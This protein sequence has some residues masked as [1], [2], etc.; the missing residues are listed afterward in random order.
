MGGKEQRQRSHILELPDFKTRGGC[1]CRG[2]NLLPWEGYTLGTVGRFEAGRDGR[3][4][5]EVHLEL[6][7]VRHRPRICSGCGRPCAADHD[8]SERWVRDLPILGA[9][10]HLLV[11]R[12][13]VACP[14]C[15]PKV[16]RLAW[17]DPYAR[18]T[19]RLAENVA[20]LCKVLPV[21][22]VADYF[23]L[24]WKAVKRID[25]SYLSRTLGPVDLGGVTRLAIDEFAIQ[26]GHRY[27][28]VVIDPTCKRVLWVGRGRSREEVRPFFRLL[29]PER[30]RLIEAVAMD[31][32]AA[33]DREHCPNAEVVYDLF[34]VVA[35]YGREVVDRVR[36]D[37]ANRLRDD[38]P[39]RKVIKGARWLL[40]R[41][42]DNIEKEQDRV[43][44]DELLAANR[45]HVNSETDSSLGRELFEQPG[46]CVRPEPVGGPGG[47]AEHFR[48]R[49]QR[50]PREVAELDQLGR[51][52]VVR[53]Q[54]R[55]RLVEGDDVLVG[56]RGSDLD[57]ADVV[58]DH[59]AAAL[60]RLAPPGRLHQD[61]AHGLGGGAEE[62]AA[63]FPAPPRR[64]A[65]RVADEP[66]VRFM[67]QRRRL[68][69]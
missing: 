20:R 37:E 6:L 33:Y 58:S 69:R 5:P 41:N 35:K 12:V 4:R 21:K 28:T 17:L 25:K 59:A 52:R 23:D 30:C 64:L 32:N 19:T 42:R 54:P 31:M 60:V 55:Q 7:P 48:A 57:F 2:M 65:R 53:R 51:G 43:R 49:R 39:A 40:L 16:E 14:D 11:H 3:V 62:V 56:L 66:H 22:H 24:D 26:K 68:E 10:T 15:G 18:V 44:L 27:A 46:L 1:R 63:V 29:G 50:E 61:A 47:D 67:H 13:R 9:D 38:K 45:R 34:H 36:V 8:T